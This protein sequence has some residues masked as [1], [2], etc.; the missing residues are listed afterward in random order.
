MQSNPR[1]SRRFFVDGK[2]SA[3]D[4]MPAR[5][6]LTADILSNAKIPRSPRAF[7]KRAFIAAFQSLLVETVNP[8]LPPTLKTTR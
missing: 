8:R 1:Q 7:A 4:E 5:A 6:S 2:Q 3:T